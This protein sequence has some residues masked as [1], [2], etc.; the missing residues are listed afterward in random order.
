MR[1]IDQAVQENA[2]EELENDFKW[3]T[4]EDFEKAAEGKNFWLFG[5]GEGV[6]FFF[7]K[8]G[9]KFVP[10]GV[11]DND[12]NKQGQKATAYIGSE[13]IPQE[14]T[15]S[16]PDVLKGCEKSNI[17]VLIGSLR[18]YAEIGKQ[19]KELGIN[20]GFSLFAME[21]NEQLSNGNV[22]T[23]KEDWE[24]VYARECCSLPI[25][26]DK[27]LLARDECGGH[28]KQ[29]LL[30]LAE[31]NP[32]L[33]LVWINDK[34]DVDIPDN[35]RIVKPSNHHAYINELETAH[36][37]L[38]GD[39]IPEY[40]IKR[41]GQKYIHIKHWAS[42]TLKK[43]YM[44]LPNYLD[45]TSVK[46]YYVHNNEA[47]D[48]VFVGSKFDEDSC[49][50]GFD[51]KGECIRVG[52]P[53]TDVLF[54]DGVREKVFRELDINSDC[55]TLMYAPTFRAKSERT[56]AGRMRE[57]DLDFSRLLNALKKKFGGD[58]QILLRIHP[59]VAMESGN[60]HLPDYVKNVS[61]YPDSQE[62]VAASDIMISDYS[63]IMFE[64]AF[65]KRPVFL[66]APD[67]EDYVNRERELLL[68]Y[69]S[70][71]FPIAK[72]NDELER[73]V[74]DFDE[75]VYQRKLNEMLSFYEVNE[76]GMAS[77]RAAEFILKLL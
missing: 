45:I 17:V 27:I 48:Y 64:P 66:Y 9:D 20:T 62:L 50:S 7:D 5:V 2:Y 61:F 19:L 51:F 4:W 73:C 43:F 22:K 30:Q 57:I 56:I 63:S 70:L 18:Y 29:I 1:L 33:D 67:M 42:L 72:S 34:N 21:L 38:F 53:R 71:P 8:Y 68:D 58:W 26:Q 11:L 37:W 49:R 75:K 24:F 47:M 6:D 15:I 10:V 69:N 60:V 74:L 46:D 55:R 32:S 35:I 16:S 54:K 28:G 44:D 23:D 31:V 52:S 41:E 12:F 25:K 65:I 13:N 3:Q 14:M 77:R 76:D 40:A 59:Y 36:I 39:M